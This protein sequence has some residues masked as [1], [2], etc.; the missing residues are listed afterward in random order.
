MGRRDKA[1]KD[2]MGRDPVQLSA[3]PCIDSNEM[4]DEHLHP[5]AQAAVRGWIEEVIVVR[6]REGCGAGLGAA[7]GGKRGGFLH[8]GEDE[9]GGHGLL[10]PATAVGSSLVRSVWDRRV[11]L[12]LILILVPLEDL[13]D[14]V[15]PVPFFHSWRAC[16]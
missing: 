9:G 12:F 13:C 8:V 3:H 4:C 6:W 2:E 1:K 10:W 5:G 16:V 11:K 7:G 15:S 14:G